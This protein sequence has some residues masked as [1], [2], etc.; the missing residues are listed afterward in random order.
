MHA[1]L[2]QQRYNPLGSA[3][4]CS[5]VTRDVSCQAV[6]YRRSAGL[7]R[8]I[9]IR[10]QPDGQ[11]VDGTFGSA[12]NVACTGVDLARFSSSLCSWHKITSPE[13]STHPVASA[14]SA[15]AA[16]EESAAPEHL[17]GI[18]VPSSSRTGRHSHVIDVP[19]GK[20][21]FLGDRQRN[22]FI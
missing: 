2:L 1:W 13:S 17:A 12:R 7:G 10:V 5:N 18:L 16:P 4:W 9:S 3:R 6:S 11:D 14:L 19:E 8:T 22:R 20:E 15:Q 21:T